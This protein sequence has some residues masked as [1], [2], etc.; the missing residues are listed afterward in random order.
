MPS[1]PPT[2]TTVRNKNPPPKQKGCSPTFSRVKPKAPTQK[3]QDCNFKHKKNSTRP[4]HYHNKTPRRITVKRKGK[5][6]LVLVSNNLTASAQEITENYKQ[7]WQIELLFKWLKQH[8]KLK[9]FLGRSANAVK[10]QLRRINYFLLYFIFCEGS[11]K[12]ASLVFRLP[13]PFRTYIR[14]ACWHTKSIILLCVPAFLFI[15]ACTC[16]MVAMVCASNSL[17]DAAGCASISFTG[18]PLGFRNTNAIITLSGCAPQCTQSKNCIVGVSLRCLGWCSDT[19][20]IQLSPK[21]LML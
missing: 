21:G 5:E 17:G 20:T 8:L 18:C 3:H 15:T 16:L 13:L 9:R 14:F 10:L 4:N 6:P 2:R 1:F 11:L 19:T 7:R 12:R